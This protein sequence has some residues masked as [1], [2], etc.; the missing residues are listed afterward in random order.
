MSQRC[1]DHLTANDWAYH[2]ALRQFEERGRGW[3]DKGKEAQNFPFLV[4]QDI[5]VGKKTGTMSQ[6]LK[7]G[8]RDDG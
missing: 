6:S 8:R 5:L 7:G 2:G 3:E 1:P 4:I